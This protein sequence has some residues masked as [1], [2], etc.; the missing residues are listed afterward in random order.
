MGKR[1]KMREDYGEAGREG[2]V[3]PHFFSRSL[4]LVPN[5]QEPGTG[6]SIPAGQGLHVFLFV[7]PLNCHL[8]AIKALG[9]MRVLLR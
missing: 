8:H 2:L 7:S 3:L 6:Y 4:S 9:C 1:K 5:N